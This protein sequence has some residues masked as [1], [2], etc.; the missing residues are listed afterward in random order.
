MTADRRQSRERYALQGASRKMLTIAVALICGMAF[1]G[2]WVAP[3]VVTGE[4]WVSIVATVLAAAVGLPVLA[5]AHRGMGRL[6]RATNAA[7]EAR[8][9]SVDDEGRHRDF[10]SKIADALDMV[11]SEDEA[12][13]VIERVLKVVVPGIRPSC[14]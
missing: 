4:P 8:Q 9:R 6:V 5:A 2:S 14:C 12:L 3:L 10:Q 1:L 13:R 11:D 7:A